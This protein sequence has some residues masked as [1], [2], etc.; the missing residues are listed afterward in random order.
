MASRLEVIP[1]TAIPTSVPYTRSVQ[2]IVDEAE[3]VLAVLYRVRHE[4][5]ARPDLFDPDAQKRIDEAI[6]RALDVLQ[7][8]GSQLMSE[9]HEAE[10]A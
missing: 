2:R 7:S 1:V 10:A 9:Q 5:S 6:V 3:Y 8:G 4:A